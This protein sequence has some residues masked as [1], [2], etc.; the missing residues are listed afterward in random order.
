M[1]T[2]DSIFM[3]CTSA[4]FKIGWIELFSPK[5]TRNPKKKYQQNH[6]NV[7]NVLSCYDYNKDNFRQTVKHHHNKTAFSRNIV[8]FVVNHVALFC[9]MSLK[10]FY[11]LNL[12]SDIVLWKFNRMF[13]LNIKWSAFPTIC[14][15]GIF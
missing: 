9:P 4:L 15:Q 14:S 10:A 2:T 5:C 6:A 3:A 8:F 7:H 12:K 1:I 11:C 13:G